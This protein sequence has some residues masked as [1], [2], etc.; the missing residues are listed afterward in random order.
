MDVEKSVLNGQIIRVEQDDPRGTK[1]IQ[2]RI[3][4]QL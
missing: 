1:Y 4:Y 3:K 2:M